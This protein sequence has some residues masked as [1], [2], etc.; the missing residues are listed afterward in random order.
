VLFAR[1][2][3]ADADDRAAM[4]DQEPAA[5]SPTNRGYFEEA[6]SLFRRVTH[7]R[8]SL[9]ANPAENRLTEITAAV[10]ESVDGLTCHVIES[11]LS[12]GIAIAEQRL[13]ESPD[14]AER[15]TWGRARDEAAELLARLRG[16]VQ[17]RVQIR[18]QRP[19]VS[20][21]VQFIDL[22]LRIF[23]RAPAFGEIFVF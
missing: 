12:R 3:V 18:T 7:Y 19:T 16:L 9:G 4:V 23:S 6:V 2:H 11:A 8:P 15:E 22:E 13:L 20:T 14:S 17:P 5:Q 10:L 21:Q 1:T